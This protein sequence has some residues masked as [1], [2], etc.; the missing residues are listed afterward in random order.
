MSKLNIVNST[1]SSRNEESNIVFSG[2]LEFSGVESNPKSLVNCVGDKPV[3]MRVGLN[4]RQISEIL[5]CTGEK[6]KNV[7]LI[8]YDS[9]KTTSLPQEVINEATLPAK[10]KIEVNYSLTKC[11]KAILRSLAD[12][13]KYRDIAKNHFLSIHTVKCHVTNIFRKLGVNNR[14]LAILKYITLIKTLYY[15]VLLCQPEMFI[16]VDLL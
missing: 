1:S 6:P 9:E 13:L 8:L 15:I 3:I 2:K 11:E 12:G 10:N 5:D 4:N 16:D 7:H 14:S